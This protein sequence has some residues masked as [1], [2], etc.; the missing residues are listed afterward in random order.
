MKKKVLIITN[1]FKDS[2][3][4]TTTRLR[5]FLKEKGVEC[6]CA[7]VD[8]KTK[9]L[10]PV[11]LDN[12]AFAMILGG[13]GT[14]MQF[15]NQLSDADLPILGINMGHL[16]YLAETDSANAEKILERVL[17]GDYKIQE[18]MML[19]GSVIKNGHAVIKE[20][21]VND[22]VITRSGRLQV[23]CFNI[24]INGKL[25]KNYNADGVI[26]STP[27]GSTAYNLS[28]GGP[29]V[30]PGAEILI[31]TPISPHTLMNRSLVLKATDNVE[32]EV[33]A[34][35]EDETEE[36]MEATFDGKPIAKLS[37]GDRVAV[38]RGDRYVKMISLN[39]ISFMEIL[40]RKMKES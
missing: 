39:E 15:A 26:L 4:K 16:G 37:M 6:V 34:T 27:T 22:V 5:K 2:E 10:D 21:A 18:R 20:T 19:S 12:I 31:F 25:L 32:I 36:V 11:L 33:L 3:M 23:L 9:K 14:I 7:S 1:R 24:Y 8:R 38:T 17:D 30:D 13:D 29:I 28:A 35:H 40:H